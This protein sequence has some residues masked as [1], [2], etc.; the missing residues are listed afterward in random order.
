[1]REALLEQYGGEKIAPDA[2]ILVDSVVEGVGVQ[3]L[4]GL[5]IRKYGV[6][7][8]QSAKRG[9]LELSPVL[10]RNWIGYA[11]LVRQGILA[12]RE[13]EK[14][15]SQQ[16]RDDL[17]ALIAEFSVVKDEAPAVDA[18]KAEGVQ[19]DGKGGGDDQG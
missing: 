13:L 1:M 10:S 2:Q 5:Y 9:R 11:N 14:G 3:K 12:L 16:G 17:D 18:P 19:V 6:I 15:R 7:D 8:S 4:L